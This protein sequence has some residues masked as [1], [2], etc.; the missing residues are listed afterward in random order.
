[1]KPEKGDLILVKFGKQTKTSI[2]LD[3][4]TENAQVNKTIIT[5]IASMTIY[6]N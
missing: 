6:T 2:V 5:R 1:M 3:R 4:Y